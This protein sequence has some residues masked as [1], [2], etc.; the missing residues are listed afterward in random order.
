M[1]VSGKT[2]C[3]AFPQILAAKV[4]YLKPMQSIAFHYGITLRFLRVDWLRYAS[5]ATEMLHD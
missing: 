5:N 3:D 4:M 1:T 2:A